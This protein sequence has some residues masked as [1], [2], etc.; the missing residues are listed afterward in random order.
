MFVKKG[1][2]RGAGGEARDKRN[3]RKYKIFKTIFK[4]NYRNLIE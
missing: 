3:K 2:G 1:K 4:Y